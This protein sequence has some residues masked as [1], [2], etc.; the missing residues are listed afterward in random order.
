MVLDVVQKWALHEQQWV[1]N[2]FVVNVD[3]FRPAVVGVLKPRPRP[4]SSMSD[5]SLV[6]GQE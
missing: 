4:N 1:E 6:V 2:R 5:L 3:D